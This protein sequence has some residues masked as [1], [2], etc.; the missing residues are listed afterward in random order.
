M[1]CISHSNSLTYTRTHNE[2]FASANGVRRVSTTCKGITTEKQC[3]FTRS[4]ML[5]IS[6]AHR[7]T[8]FNFNIRLFLSHAQLTQVVCRTDNLHY[9]VHQLIW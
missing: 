8:L 2:I 6:N 5:R 7:Y 1:F 3:T 4:Q 9:N